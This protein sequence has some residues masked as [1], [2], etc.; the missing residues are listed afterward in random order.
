MAEK[1]A[2]ASYELI[3]NAVSY[4]SVS[5]DVVYLLSETERYMEICVS[6]DASSGRVTNLRA[7]LERLRMDPEKAFLDE[8]SR[9][10]TGVGGRAALGLAR[11][12]HEGQLDLVFEMDGSRVTM[13]ARC[14]R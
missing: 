6:N 9:S 7:H 1:I 12:C 3:E 11:I 4:G 2:L 5:G 14:P 10:V 8:M 13:R